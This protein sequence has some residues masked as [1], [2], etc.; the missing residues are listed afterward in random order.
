MVHNFCANLP[1]NHYK[2]KDVNNV[3]DDTDYT[4]PISK[5]MN[6]NL[7]I[8]I[9][10]TQT[11]VLHIIQLFVMIECSPY[12]CHLNSISYFCNILY[13]VN[14][15]IS[16][17]E[18][19]FNDSVTSKYDNN[20]LDIIKQLTNV[21]FE[22]NMKFTLVKISKISETTLDPEE[23]DLQDQNINDVSSNHLKPNINSAPCLFCFFFYIASE[24]DWIQFSVRYQT[25]VRTGAVTAL[26]RS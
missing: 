6:E 16:L 3:S 1:R 22:F 21:S 11:P 5:Q 7:I 26:C 14:S 19:L 9:S 4:V 17:N 23:L 2:N 10:H 20:K 25:I 24:I 8:V 12:C 18:K 13:Q 15:C